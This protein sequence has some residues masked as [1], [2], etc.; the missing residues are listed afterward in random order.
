MTLKS[1]LAFRIFTM[2]FV[3]EHTSQHDVERQTRSARAESG[4]QFQFGSMRN[5]YF[6][7]LI[8]L[9]TFFEFRFEPFAN[10]TGQAP[11]QRRLK[12]EPM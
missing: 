8:S 1:V 9:P 7:V 12:I 3:D 6:M 4:L 5:D 11:N 10:P 2:Y